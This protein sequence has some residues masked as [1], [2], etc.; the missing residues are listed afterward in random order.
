MR[1]LEFKQ[2]SYPEEG[3]EIA[4]RVTFWG[5]LGGALLLVREVLQRDDAS[6]GDEGG[7]GD[8]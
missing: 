2:S 3:Y 7:G 6:A 8:D 1:T 5:G 4:G